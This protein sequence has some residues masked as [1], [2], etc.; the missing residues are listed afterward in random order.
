M[1]PVAPDLPLARVGWHSDLSDQ[2][3]APVDP[4]ATGPSFDH[5]P[6]VLLLLSEHC[7][8]SVHHHFLFTATDVHQGETGSC[9]AKNCTG[10]W[11]A[12]LRHVRTT[13]SKDGDSTVVVLLANTQMT[14][15]SEGRVGSI[16]QCKASSK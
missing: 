2:S 16:C 15:V 11:P 9:V 7:L 3:A 13:E 6:A 12:L 5:S 4:Q 8:E 14:T 1:D 10:G